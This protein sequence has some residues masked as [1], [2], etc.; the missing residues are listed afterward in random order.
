MANRK[1]VH[2]EE[3]ET[4]VALARRLLAAQ[5]PHWAALPLARVQADST[6]NDMYRLGADM[7]VRLP[8]RAGAVTP[9]DKEHEWLPRLAPRLPLA[10]PLV[11]AKGVPQ[12]D[13][14]YL[15]R[16]RIWANWSS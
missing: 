12:G 9:M 10:V 6:D 15:P 7:A 14:P 8:R 2:A 5:F 13:Y 16:G 1:Q 11:R 4:D 3:V